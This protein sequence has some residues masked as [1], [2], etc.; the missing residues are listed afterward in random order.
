MDYYQIQA[1][2]KHIFIQDN[3]YEPPFHNTGTTIQTLTEITVSKRKSN[4]VY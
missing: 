3:L 1:E 4:P 2:K